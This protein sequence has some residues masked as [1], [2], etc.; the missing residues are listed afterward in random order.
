[1]TKFVCPSIDAVGHRVVHGMQHT[2]PERVTP[3]LLD[4]LRN[5]SPCDPQHLPVEIALIEA[6]QTLNPEATQ[7]ACFDTLFH[8]A[9]PRVAEN[10]GDSQ[11]IFE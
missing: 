9:M 7:V 11:A 1:M 3:E 10:P 8:V 2:A 5:I 4:D 6:F